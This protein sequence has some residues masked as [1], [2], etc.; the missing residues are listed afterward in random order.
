MNSLLRIQLQFHCL[1]TA[2]FGNIQNSS[3]FE[4]I[5]RL[6]YNKHYMR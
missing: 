6:S 2:A 4:P 5:R 3:W 1:T